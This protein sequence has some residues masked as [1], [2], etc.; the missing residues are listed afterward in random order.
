[1]V[2]TLTDLGIPEKQARVYSDRLHQGD[3]LVI[4]DGT[5]DEIG[6]AEGIFSDRGIQ[7]WSVYNSPQ[8]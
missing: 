5:E 1:L 6:R 3:Y 2:R 4:V 7:D 8:A